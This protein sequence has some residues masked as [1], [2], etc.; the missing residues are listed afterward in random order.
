[1]KNKVDR[2]ILIPCLLG[3]MVGAVY[4]LVYQVPLLFVLTVAAIFIPWSILWHKKSSLFL[5]WIITL[6]SVFVWILV[7]LFIGYLAQQFEWAKHIF[8]FP[9]YLNYA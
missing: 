6:C 9:Y 3:A 8:Y 7:V 4:L 1:M 5:Q 2:N